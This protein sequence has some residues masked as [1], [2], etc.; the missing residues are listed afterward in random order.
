MKH[1]NLNRLLPVVACMALPGALLAQKPAR[2]PVTVIQGIS[3]DVKV[4]KI[5]LLAVEEGKTK[6]V[7]SA[8]VDDKHAFAFALPHP[9]EGFYY[10]SSAARS[11]G[12]RVY[13]KPGDQLNVELNG[14]AYTVKSGSAEN[15]LLQQ[16]NELAAPVLKPA[17][18][19]DTVTYKSYFPTLEKTLPKVAAFKKTVNTPNKS[20][21]EL[22]KFAT[23]VDIEHAALR[24]LL[25]PHSEHPQLKDYPA[26]YK[27]IVQDKK[28]CD[29]KLLQLAE[30]EDLLR[31]YNTYNLLLTKT[32]A[33]R[34]KPQEMFQKGVDGFCS[35][36]VKA[37]FITSSLGSYRTYESLIAAIEPVKKYLATDVE[38]KRY[39]EYEKSV[40]KF[41]KG[42]AGFNFS[43]EDLS[44]KPV[45][46]NDLKG[47]VVVVDVW[48]TWCGPC[49]A[50]LPHLQQ[51]EEEMNG[52]DVTFVGVS[53]DEGKD[54]EKWKAFVKEKEMKGVQLFVNGWSDI[55][56]FYGIN[57]IPRFMVFDKNGKIVN[58]DA[59]R[60]STP[61]LKALI[62]ELLKG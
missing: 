19:M 44:G 8:W 38:K 32:A 6:E 22:L 52:K 59:P 43:G 45:S 49:K 60:P 46:F 29:D 34:P 1:M 30:A 26:Y 23:D 27:T 11:N 10:L 28:Y 37:L 62:E 50:E 2:V 54:K 24:F 18:G 14:A 12:V 33:D 42:E 48:A 3:A 7:A 40:R 21:N 47:K 25:I 20:F 16:W 5:T 61:E 15:K 56:K 31:L 36:R 58:V 57:G 53:V 39:L 17:M 4:E 55:T 13:L 41:S 9:Q 35:D 51:L